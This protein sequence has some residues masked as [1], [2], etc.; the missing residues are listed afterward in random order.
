MKNA[1]AAF[2]TTFVVA[3]PVTAMADRLSI[4]YRKNFPIEILKLPVATIESKAD[5]GGSLISSIAAK[6]IPAKQLGEQIDFRVGLLLGSQRV[7]IGKAP[8]PYIGENNEGTLY[9]SGNAAI[10]IPRSDPSNPMGCYLPD[11]AVICEP[12]SSMGIEAKISDAEQIEFSPVA[13][14]QELLYIGGNSKSISI[15][16]REFTGDYIKAAFPQ[17]YK[18]DISED[19]IIGFKGARIE[20]IKANNTEIAYRVIKHLD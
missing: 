8:L 1:I 14:K 20:V 9:G 19:K 3:F 7:I 5:V 17:E 16:Y 2:A 12:L 4:T 10:F 15:L 13:N 18:Y 11:L 6:K